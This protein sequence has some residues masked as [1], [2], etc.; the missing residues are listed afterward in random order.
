MKLVSYRVGK[1]IRGGIVV[2]DKILD[3]QKVLGKREQESILC[4]LQGGAPALKAAR[5]AVAS[6]THP[7]ML[8]ALVGTVGSVRLEAPIPRP[9]K[10]LALAGNYAEHIKEGGK[11]FKVKDTITPRIFIKPATGVIGHEAPIPFPKAAQFIDWEGELGVVIGKS[12]KYVPRE[13]AMQYVAGYTVFHDVSERKLLIRKRKE[14]SEWDKFFDWLN[15]KWFDG[16]APM[17]PW[18][19]TRDE[20]RNPNNLN[21]ETR[22]NGKVE[23]S[24]NT[25]Q[26]IF[27]VADL[28]HYASQI[29]T[30][31][32]G[33]VIATGTPAG[34]GSGK[35]ICMKPGDVAEIEIEKLGVLRNR[36]VREAK[37]RS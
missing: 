30:L 1:E 11:T 2:G 8:R 18:L 36:I 12:A 34:V 7:R 19:V 6:L 4:L 29:F 27:D 24:G 26:M 37:S 35:G 16:F 13:R 20:I 17:G 32:P 28:V 5:E 3:L 14:S 21:V 22:I 31:E 15:G 9:G 25:S 23:Q 10:I 33:D